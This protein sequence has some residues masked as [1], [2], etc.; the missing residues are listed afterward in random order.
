MFGTCQAVAHTSSGECDTQCLCLVYANQWLPSTVDDGVAWT[1]LALIGV[2]PMP[3]PLSELGKRLFFETK[4]SSDGQ[5]AC[6]TCHDPHHAFA[7]PRPVSLGVYDRQGT[8][9]SQSLTHLGSDSPQ[10]AFFG[11]GEPKLC[12]SKYLCLQPT[13]TR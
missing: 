11:T 12:T 13:P 10:C 8:R 1:E 5:I 3:T 2:P 7:D 4:S 6:I 9:N